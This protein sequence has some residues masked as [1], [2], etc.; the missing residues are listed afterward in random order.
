[1]EEQ[2]L[3]TEQLDGGSSYISGYTGCSD[4]SSGYKFTNTVMTQGVRS[5]DG[6]AIITFLGNE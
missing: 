1:M 3:L 6:Y 2:D 5:G 4:H